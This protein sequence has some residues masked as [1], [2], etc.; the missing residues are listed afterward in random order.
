MNG[1]KF[2]CYSM[3][4]KFSNFINCIIVLGVLNFVW[5]C[6]KQTTHTNTIQNNKSLN[7]INNDTMTQIKNPYYSKDD[8]Q[9]IDIPNQ[10]WKKV[11]PAEVYHIAREKGTEWAF[12][13]K[14]WNFEGNGT[15]RCVACGNALFKS[16]AKFASSCG[17]PSFFETIRPNSII[18]NEDNSHGMQRTE[19]V[20]GR[21]N[22]HLGHI[23]D[24]GPK[25]TRK[26]FC[27]NS[28]V[29]EFEPDL[30]SAK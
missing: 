1:T 14:Y 2:N 24:D 6:K 21:C 28:L 22:S 20:C 5:S 23:F 29:I 12:S 9:T 25:P 18:Y 26:R 17:W 13:G 27:I 4:L 8:T 11:L 10:E 15:Y 7:S 3:S 19:T 30:S 16:T